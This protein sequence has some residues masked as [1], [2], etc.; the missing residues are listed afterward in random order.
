MAHR[1]TVPAAI[2]AVPAVLVAAFALAAPAN[3][4]DITSN[5]ALQVCKA[6][7]A[8]DAGVPVDT[9]T[10]EV[11]R[12]KTI[13]R[14]IKFTLDVSV[15]GTETATAK[16]DVHKGRGEVTTLKVTAR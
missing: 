12:Q 4:D 15:N 3:A 1:L 7:I 11:R 14:W 9:V 10:V 8:E 5:D 13:S 2:A 6:A 16:C